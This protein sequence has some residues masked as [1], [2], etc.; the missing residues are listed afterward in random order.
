[1]RRF[2][3]GYAVLMIGVAL[4]SI[5]GISPAVAQNAEDASA[6]GET[7]IVVTGVRGSLLRSSDAKRNA[8]TIVDAISSEELGKFPDRNVAEALGN[9]P[10]ITVGRDGRGEGKNITIRGLGQDFA[11]TTLNGRILP[12]DTGDRSFA[13]D[14]LPSEMISGAE[15]KKAVQAS[16]LEGSIGG[17][18]DLKSARPFD[19]KGFHLSGSLEGNYGDLSKKFGFKA[20]GVVSTTFADDTMGILVSATYSKN[21]F[22]TDNLGEYFPVSETELS[23]QTDFNGDGQIDQNPDGKRYIFPSFYSNGVVLGERERL[24]LSGAYQ[25][26]PSD[27]LT[28]LIDGLYSRY[29]EIASNYRQSNFLNPRNDV[30]EFD[31]ANPGNGLKWVPGSIKTDA[32]GVVTNFAIN[33]LVAEVLTTDEPRTVNTYQIGGHIDWQPSERLSLSFDGYQGQAKR[34][35]GGK[36]RFVVAGITGASAVFATRENGLPDLAITIPGGR[37]IDQATDNDFRA[38]YIGIQGD[39]LQDK[40]YGLKLDGAYDVA[41]SGLRAIK[42]GASLT[43]RRKTRNVIDNAFTT[44]CN[45]CGYPFTFGEIGASVVRPFPVSGLLNDRAGNFPRNFPVFD[46]DTYLAALPRADNNLAILNPATGL[47]YPTGYSTQIVEPD[48]IQSFRI[49]E[50]T[51]AGYVQAD[52][53]GDNWRGDIGLRIVNTKVNSS[54][55]NFTIKSI[56]KLPGNTADF[57]IQYNDPTPA[58]GGGSYTK[59]LPAANFAYDFTDQLRLRLAAAQVIARPTFEQLSPASDP[60]SSSSGTFVIFDAGNP[61]LKPTT[62]NQFDASLEYYLGSRGSFS[63]AAFYKDIKNFVTSVPVNVTITPTAQPTGAPATI[64]FTRFIVT[65]GDS[66]KVFGVEIGGQYFFENGFGI[67]AN[68]TFNDSKARTGG[69]KTKLAGAIPFSANAKLFYEK[70]G[71]NAQVSYNYASRYT[72]AEQGAIA[73]LSVKEDAYNEVSA[74]F[75]YDITENITIYVEGSNLLNSAIKRYN[76]YRNVP[77]FYEASGRT[78]FFGIRGKM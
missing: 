18:V 7:E 30:N 65:N 12:T 47:P 62:A 67:Q 38:H 77:A 31:P 9:I 28:I 59:F 54:G 58:I 57:D 6:N 15:V 53:S 14:V 17:N 41:D 64:D 72:Q 39:N 21:K 37:T 1:M 36:N 46:I 16:A 60:T 69:V 74:S 78:F 8:S 2:H 66:A 49:R 3:K 34:N 35:T 29:K 76:T 52:F 55:A 23:Q 10:G 5:V 20:S 33:D 71:I 75:G 45:Y 56:V 51:Y 25:Y 63:V 61:N 73:G 70:N 42:F 13:F 26:K 44:S 19:R 40:I 50:K 4:G 32:N 22:R 48:L 27:T 11:I 68:A 24:G 43:D